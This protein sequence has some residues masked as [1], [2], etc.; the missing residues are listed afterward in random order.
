LRAD[1]R[2]F[3]CNQTWYK[4]LLGS[5]SKIIHMRDAGSNPDGIISE[6]EEIL[7]AL[8]ESH[9]SDAFLGIWASRLGQGMLM[10]KVDSIR[11]DHSGTV[12]LLREQ[13]LDG[14]KLHTHMLYLKEISKV[15]KFN[16]LLNNE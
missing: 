16:K 11:K 13:D 9:E 5:G 15:H 7:K 8:I 10:C 1:S 6:K 4:I 2:F 12:I 3:S 14:K